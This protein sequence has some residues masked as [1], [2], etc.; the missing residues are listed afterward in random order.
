ML[1][2]SAVLQLEPHELNDPMGRQDRGK[3]DFEEISTLNIRKSS[4]ARHFSPQSS[5]YARREALPYI[6]L[7]V[8]TQKP[9]HVEVVF[10]CLGQVSDAL[11]RRL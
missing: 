3:V 5:L 6:F 10:P 8:L 9:E 7:P 2:G 4:R 1:M 11:C